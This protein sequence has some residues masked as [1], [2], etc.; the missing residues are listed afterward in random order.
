MIKICIGLVLG[1]AVGLFCGWAGIPSPAP[2]VIP[3]ALVVVSMTLGFIAVNAVATGRS[4]TTRHL[5]GGP[6]GKPH[7]HNK[8][9]S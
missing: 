2:P 4:H 1:F 9:K 7:S 5:S 3:G 6:T 8:E